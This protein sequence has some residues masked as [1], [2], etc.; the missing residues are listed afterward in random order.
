MEKDTDFLTPL[1]TKMTAQGEVELQTA[2]MPVGDGD[3][4]AVELHGMLY[5]GKSK[6]GATVL[7]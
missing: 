5:D 6:A 7:T 2:L 1:P 4:S 3:G